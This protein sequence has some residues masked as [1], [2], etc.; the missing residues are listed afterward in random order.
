[1]KKT[2][3]TMAVACALG[4]SFSALGDDQVAPG[5]VT[6]AATGGAQSGG[7]ASEAINEASSSYNSTL[8]QSGNI[9]FKDVANDVNTDNKTTIQDDGNVIHAQ[10]ADQAVAA[11]DLNATI[12]GNIMV[13]DGVSGIS[14]AGALGNTQTGGV[15]RRSSNDIASA[16]SGAAGIAVVS[17]ST[18]NMGSLQQSTVVQSNL[19]IN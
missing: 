14:A 1:M 10:R 13:Q 11:S 19:K 12:S 5:D 2:L 9:D 18:G 8:N 7:D 15:T 4:T 17:Q 6:T 3:L 16:F